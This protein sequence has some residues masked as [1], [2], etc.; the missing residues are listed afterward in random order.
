MA[1]VLGSMSDGPL[2]ANNIAGLSQ[3]PDTIWLYSTVCNTPQRYFQMILVIVFRPIWQ[4]PT[5]QGPQYRPRIVGIR[6]ADMQKREP[7][8]SIGGPR[9]KKNL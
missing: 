1:G 4:L 9:C 5:C 6:L 2:L 7:T 3:V 8:C